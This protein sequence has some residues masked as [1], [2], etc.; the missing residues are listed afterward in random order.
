M[1]SWGTALYSNDTSCD[2]RDT[3]NEVYPLVS[4]E[5]ATEIIFKEYTNI[6]NSDI[7]DNDYADFWFALADWQWKHGILTDEIKDK[8]I[9]LL[10][11]QTGIDEWDGSDIKKRLAVMEKL[12]NQLKSPQPEIKIPKPKIAKPKH[13]AGDII[14]VLTG[15]KENDPKNWI[16]NIEECIY[17]FIYSQ[18]ISDKICQTLNPPYDAHNKY[19]AIL[20]V[21]TEKTP[22]SQYVDGVF[23]EYSVYAFYDYISDK[24]P[25]I[26]ILKKCGFLPKYL[27]YAN[28]KGCIETQG[29]C[30][31][32]HLFS[33]NFKSPSKEQ[34][35]SLE[36]HFY[37]DEANRFYELFSAKTYLSDVSWDWEIY[38]AF[39][40]FFD[41]KAQLEK[42]NI[43]YD[44]LLNLNILNPV[45]RTPKEINQIII[46][47]QKVWQEKV[48]A[49]ENSEAYQIAT[50]E[51]KILMLRALIKLDM[52]I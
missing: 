31:K 15:S 3:C 9:A 43:E 16:W 17:P 1:G 28:N 10:E 33:Q 47:E 24:K 4:I 39:G 26:D 46:N 20:C 32:F 7:I 14:I 40:G 13:K 22:H 23:D 19:I 37:P 49:L 8:A 25:T 44:N 41:I 48:L 6:V 18:K 42:A 30:Y 35:Q 50:E 12:L 29:W 52:D 34:V 51:E 21:G 38:D 5:E 27:Q 36:K 11:A 45:L 2:V